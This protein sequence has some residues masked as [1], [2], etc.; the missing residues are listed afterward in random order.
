MYKQESFLKNKINIVITVLL[1]LYYY[2][3]NLENCPLSR[4][5][6]EYLSTSFLNLSV[7]EMSKSKFVLY[8]PLAILSYLSSLSWSLVN[9]GL[10]SNSKKNADNFAIN[11]G[12]EISGLFLLIEFSKLFRYYVFRKAEK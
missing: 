9:N 8:L 1:N 11:K 7:E 12:T 10:G 4:H 3:L 2:E 6:K 5:I